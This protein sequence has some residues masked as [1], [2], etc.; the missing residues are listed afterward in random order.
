MLVQG[1][2]ESMIEFDEVETPMNGEAMAE[3]TLAA[4]WRAFGRSLDVLRG[5]LAHSPDM[6]GE[7]AAVIGSE[8]HGMMVL[9]DLPSA[10]AAVIHERL[11]RIYEALQQEDRIQ[12]RLRQLVAVATALEK[13]AVRAAAQGDHELEDEIS[14]CLRLE[15]LRAAVFGT[16]AG[17][18]TPK[19]A[20][21][22]SEISAGDV[23]LF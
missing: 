21:R 23:D 3:D 15:E 7:L 19:E 6:L 22:S 8:I 13:S 1:S 2:S 18:Y 5:E 16:S 12:Q 10:E 4:P 9:D 11:G 20:P 14:H 17:Q